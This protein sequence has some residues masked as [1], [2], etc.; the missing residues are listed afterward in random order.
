MTL[1]IDN[2]R[3]AANLEDYREIEQFIYMEARLADQL[4]YDE[5]ESLWTDDAL[6]WVPSDGA[7]YDPMKK[8]S[9][10]YDNRNRISTRL[11]QL[12]TG[13]RYAQAPPS[14][15]RRLVSNI[16][17]L[18]RVGRGEGSEATAVANFAL[19]EAKE[20]GTRMWAGQ[21]TYVLR[22]IEGRIR[23]VNKTVVL[24]DNAMPLPNMG[25]LI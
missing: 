22:V 18:E 4:Q 21:V 11:T 7:G 3:P 1:T 20:R 24:I 10:I 13:K 8:M 6:Y 17:I 2:A 12:R 5:W 16:E 25:F 23:L 19:F 14:N 15:M 9:V